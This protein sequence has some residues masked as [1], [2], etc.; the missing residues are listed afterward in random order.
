MTMNGNKKRN[1]MNT[2][3]SVTSYHMTAISSNTG[4]VKMVLFVLDHAAS[5]AAAN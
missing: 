3:N 2:Q 1:E 4:G 5:T